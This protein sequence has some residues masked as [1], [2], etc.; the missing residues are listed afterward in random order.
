MNWLGAAVLYVSS[1]CVNGK[2]T[3]LVKALPVVDH[4]YLGLIFIHPLDI[5]YRMNALWGSHLSLVTCSTYRQISITFYVKGTA[6]TKLRATNLIL[7]R[8]GLQ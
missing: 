6:Y 2:Q 3:E 5:V 1:D 4:L 7:T 8:T